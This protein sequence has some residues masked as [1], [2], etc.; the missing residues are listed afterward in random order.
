MIAPH[1]SA[2]EIPRQSM[3]NDVQLVTY[4][5]RLTGGGIRDLNTLLHGCPVKVAL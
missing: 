5:D 4:V 1:Q 3:K 2:A